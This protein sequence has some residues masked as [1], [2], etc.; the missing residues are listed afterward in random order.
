MRQ[1]TGT[2]KSPGEKIVKDIK[3]AT[4]KHYSS[5][6]KIR[7]VLDG[8][9][10]EDSI[11]ELCRREGI[12]QGIYY[13]WSKDFMEAG[14]KRLAG[15]TARAA[16]TDEVKELRREAKD[17]KEVVAEQTLELRLLKKKH[18]RR[19]GRPRMRYPASEKLE[20]IRLVEESHLSARLT[21][22]KMGIPR[23]T[24]YRWYDRYLQRGEAG[25]KDQSP[26][27][28]HVWN[29]I[30]DDVRRKVVQLA[31]KETE[32][33]PRELAVTFTDKENYFV[34]E[35]STY[36]ILK[37]H[38]L[39]TSPAFIV[40]KAASEFKDKTT[41][42]NQLWQTDFTYL[43]VLGWGWFYLS[44]I[45]DDYSR[46][47]ISWKLCANMRTEDVTDTLDLALEASGC[48]QVHVVHKPRLLSDNGSSY[49]SGDLAEWLKDKGM[50]H[51]RGAPYH[52]QTQGKIERWH[53]T[54][55]NRI[56]L[57]NYFLPGD[58]EAQIEA[59]V[60]HYNH[61]RY[62]ES[63]NNVTPADVYFGRDKAILK[64]RERIKRK[65]LEA[66]RL[67]HRQHAA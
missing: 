38:D 27:P 41:A 35:A 18:V 26:K 33:S 11:A 64:Q 61:Q 55:K 19:W 7:I 46:Y 34:S 47:I 12:S 15:D 43:K 45:L 63:I 49:V 40:I 10:G 16:N 25:L 28:K 60:D 37:A 51:S 32:L 9:R 5:E 52:P 2:R 66:R 14:K 42:I 57:E 59:F 8:L 1:T 54:L 17:L 3:R 20:I 44:T 58:L 53:Q 50:K 48:D 30:P 13:K 39:I 67:H 21:L 23:T 31:L 4:R 62:H 56:L 24:F 22:A 6:E 65:T 36:R 29:R